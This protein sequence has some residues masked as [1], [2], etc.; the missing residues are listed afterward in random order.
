MESRSIR[1]KT[2]RIIGLLLRRE[3]DKKKTHWKILSLGLLN[4]DNKKEKLGGGG[5]HV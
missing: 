5:A 1:S 2:F 3:K 4:S